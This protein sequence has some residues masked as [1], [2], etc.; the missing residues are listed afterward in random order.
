M[1]WK[2]EPKPSGWGSPN[3]PEGFMLLPDHQDVRDVHGGR[4]VAW[5]VNKPER[6]PWWPSDWHKVRGS[7]NVLD[8]KVGRWW[9]NGNGCQIGGRVSPKG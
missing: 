5:L 8:Y 3:L 2:H 1:A 7:Y 6:R 9:R 4:G